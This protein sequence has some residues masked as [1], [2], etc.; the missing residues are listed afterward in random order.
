MRPRTSTTSRWGLSAPAPASALRVS[1][2]QV[3]SRTGTRRT[4]AIYSDSQLI[5]DDLVA[6][7]DQLEAIL[8]ELDNAAW[9]TESGA[10]GWTVADVV[11]HLAQTEEMV[12]ASARGESF[13]LGSRP[14]TDADAGR[15][16]TLDEV[17]DRVVRAEQAS[18]GEVFERWRSG[19]AGGGRRAAG[20]G[21]R[22]TSPVGGRAAQAHDAGHHPAG[23]ALGSRARHHRPARHSVPRHRSAASRRVAGPG[24]PAVRLHPCRRGAAR[25]VLRADRARRRHVAIRIARRRLHDHRARPAR[26]AGSVRSGSR[27]TTQGSSRV[28]RTVPPRC[29]SCATTRAERH[30]TPGAWHTA[31]TLLPSGSRTNAP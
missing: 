1:C 16:D 2:L 29:A 14:D 19:A 6:E 8:D 20:S 7:Q 11:L 24:F 18:P 12:V 17:M 15:A 25:R 9:L 5:F 28:V 10:A 3:R 23:R 13:G 31:S 22:A 21:S 30:A 27:R 26:S 4:T